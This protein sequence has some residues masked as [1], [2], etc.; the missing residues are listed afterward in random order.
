MI[1]LGIG[2]RQLSGEVSQISAALKSWKT[3]MEL[4]QSLVVLCAL[5]IFSRCR[6]CEL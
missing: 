6:V 5:S 1:S 4:N 2:C 3:K